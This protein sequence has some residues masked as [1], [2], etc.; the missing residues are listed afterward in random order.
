MRRVGQ[1]RQ[2]RQIQLSHLMRPDASSLDGSEST[3]TLVERIIMLAEDVKDALVGWS[4]DSTERVAE[5]SLLWFRGAIRLV[6][7]L[8]LLRQGQLVSS[9]GAPRNMLVMHAN[10]NITGP[11]QKNEIN[12]WRKDF[13]FVQAGNQDRALR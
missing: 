2:Q 4:E 11:Q 12:I 3:S 9:S 10:G 8:G 6:D 5:H 1:Y 7:Q 13:K